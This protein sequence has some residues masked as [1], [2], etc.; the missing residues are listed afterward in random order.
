VSL[1]IV[2]HRQIPEDPELRRQWNDVAL[3]TERPEV[4]YT[5]EWALAVQ[6]AYRDSLNPLLFLG[7]EDDRLIGVAS[8]AANAVDGGVAFLAATTGD[9]C[10]FLSEP[11]R[12]PEFVDAVFAE[13]E[14]TKTKSLALT[15]LPEDSA[16][17]TALLAAARKYRFRV[18]MRPAYLCAQVELGSDERRTE[19]KAALLSKKKLRRYLRAME[20]EGPVSFSHLQSQAEIEA[21]MPGFA[22]AH[23]ARFQA[24]QRTSSLSTPERR[25]FLQELTR[26]FS[27]MGVVTMSMLMIGKQPVAWNYGFQFQGS[28]FWYQPT[29]DSRHEENSPGHCLLSRIVT[30]ACDM[31]GINVVDLGLGAE[32]YKERFGNSTRQTLYVAVT[33]SRR[34][35]LQEIVKYRVA[36]WVKQSPQIESAVRRVLNKFQP[37]RGVTPETKKR[38]D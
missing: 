6:C 14:R 27:G 37:V 33:K 12:R 9:Y 30:E 17:P 1:R 29:F 15:N 25:L 35:H 20:R 19:L 11:Q 24:T 26:R 16:T 21:A 10:E 38:L 8:L 23:V 13:L 18:H 34:R 36:S 31:D 28:W 5:C 32:G 22:D 4:F 2:L 7:Y 3:Q